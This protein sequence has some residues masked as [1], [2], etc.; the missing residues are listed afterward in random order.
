M[1]FDRK[2]FR[3]LV[4]YVIWR[5]GDSPDFGAIKLNK[6]LWFSDARS[7]EATGKPITGEVYTRQKYGPVPRHIDEVLE[8][9]S[10]DGVISSRSEPYFN[11]MVRRLQAHQPP[12]ISAFAPRE[13]NMVDWWIKHIDEEH[14]AVSIS[15]KSHD[16]G[17]KLAA[18]GEVLPY[19]AI[20]AKRIRPPREGHE[21]EWAR[22]AARE[23]SSK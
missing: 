19:K 21:L 3:D 8:E 7:Y 14:S 18:L 16:Y 12:D 22:T 1:E 9:L 20:L 5:S 6:V 15:E 23:L 13:M 17:W 2:K 11:F 10:R 4:L